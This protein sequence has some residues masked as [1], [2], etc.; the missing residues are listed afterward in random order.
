MRCFEIVPD[1]SLAI[2]EA[3]IVLGGGIVNLPSWPSNPDGVPL[4]LV[5][6]IDCLKLKSKLPDCS[7]PNAKL[8]VFSTYSKTEYFLDSITFTGAQQELALI[9]TG[10]TQ[11][12]QATQHTVS[13]ASGL[14][15][16]QI[17]TRLIERVV[18]S[19]DFPVFS[20]VSNM[21]P[22]GL[23]LPA[24]IL[25]EYQ[26]FCQFYSGDFPEDYSDVFY[27]VDALGYL[28]L[29]KPES[30]LNAPDLFFVQTA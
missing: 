22:N 21:V 11:V 26:F 19:E 6:T 3:A 29:K 15:M 7:F 13:S 8:Y 9:E 10:F 5:A 25:K 12:L 30:T 24:A 1:N 16:P 14:V 4:L 18:A 2:D 23:Q 27:L 17:A 28:L 20:L